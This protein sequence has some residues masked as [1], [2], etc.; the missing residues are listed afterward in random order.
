MH[1]ASSTLHSLRQSI[2]LIGRDGARNENGR[3]RERVKTGHEA[4]DIALGGG[5]MRGALHEILPQTP[6]DLAAATGFCLGIIARS[7]GARDWIWIRED[8]TLREAGQPYG[9]G[10][11]G[12][13][14]NPT[15]LLLVATRNTQDA[16]KAAEDAL[17]CH[18]LGAVLFEPWGDPKSLDLTAT[19][20]LALASE[21]SGVPI[22]ILRSGGRSASGTARTRWM[23]SSMMSVSAEEPGI[24]R[25]SINLVLN[26]QSG[27]GGPGKTWVMEWRYDECLFRPTDSLGHLSASING[28]T[29]ASSAIQL[30]RSI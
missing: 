27:A 17:H 14:L 4:V 18:A 6:N 19:R 13:G 10:L 21:D 20:R 8:Q 30:R 11:A 26:R 12:F 16:L 7:A 2:A 29:K 25:W 24:P 3:N 5:L 23:V 28:S 9:P 15:R 22:I 1:P